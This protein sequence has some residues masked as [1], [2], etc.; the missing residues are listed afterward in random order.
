MS[1]VYGPA[2]HWYEIVTESSLSNDVISY[3]L[4]IT[5]ST[6]TSTLKYTVYDSANVILNFGLWSLTSGILTFTKDSTVNAAISATLILTPKTLSGVNVLSFT[7]GNLINSPTN[8]SG[9]CFYRGINYPAASDVGIHYRAIMDLPTEL[10]TAI[11]AAVASTSIIETIGFQSVNFVPLPSL[12]DPNQTLAIQSQ[13]LKNIAKN[14]LIITRAY[15]K[16]ET[17]SNHIVSAPNVTTF[18]ASL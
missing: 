10:A 3:Y 18:L 9:L 15:D 8:Q 2:S 12:M 17:I 6:V 7:A 5:A 16:L 14:N 4:A 13:F 1:I 11:S